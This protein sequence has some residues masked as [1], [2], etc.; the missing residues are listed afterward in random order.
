MA[1]ITEYPRNPATGAI[2]GEP[3]VFNTS[4]TY[5]IPPTASPN[6]TIIVEAIGGGAGGR[7]P[8]SMQTHTDMVTQIGFNAGRGGQPGTTVIGTYR[9]GFFSTAPAGQSIAVTVGAGGTGSVQNSATTFNIG[10]HSSNV[11]IANFVEGTNGGASTC[12]Y[13]GS[14]FH[15]AAG[16]TGNATA[17]PTSTTFMTAIDSTSLNTFGP[18]SAFGSYVNGTVTATAYTGITLVPGGAAR[19]EWGGANTIGG[20]ASTDF[21][22]GSGT[23]SIAAGTDAATGSG[24]SGGSGGQR[25]MSAST[26]N[27]TI[28]RGG[29]GAAPGGGG[30]G[31][32]NYMSSA[33]STNAHTWNA[34]QR[35]GN[36]GAGRVRIYYQA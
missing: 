36:G 35:G 16:G 32:F 31:F 22:N 7:G 34:G 10:S 13:G 28:G 2:Y 17:T 20:A 1:Y 15:T 23:Y 4:G 6:S 9:L 27:I 5:V 30:G 26:N 3:T 11:A 12:S 25:Y 21:T 29:N 33:A 24:A 8:S 19:T 14:T 18:T